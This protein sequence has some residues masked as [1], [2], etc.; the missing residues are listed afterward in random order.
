MVPIFAIW[1]ILV[2]I[3]FAV[4]FDF[5]VVWM[6]YIPGHSTTNQISV[7]LA[8]MEKWHLWRKQ[9]EKKINK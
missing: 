9:P 8:A 3:H 6:E 5:Y 1:P 7:Q 2:Q 4:K